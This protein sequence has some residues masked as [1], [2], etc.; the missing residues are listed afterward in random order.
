MA[1]L[2]SK[3]KRLFGDLE[4]EDD[5]NTQV[6]FEDDYIG[7][8]AGGSTLFA[9]SGSSVIVN[10]EGGDI[11]F[12][13][14]SDGNANLIR[15]DAFKN[16]VGI[17]THEPTDTLDINSNSIRI[18]SSNTPPSNTAIGVP[19]RICWDSD[20]LY[21]CIATDTWKRILMNSW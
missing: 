4:F 10:N 16:R 11:D 18:R 9:V 19:G 20:Y 8:V 21:V 17:L 12:Q 7:L 14:Q 3:G 2:Y 1:H 15:T 6:D 5:T 13:V